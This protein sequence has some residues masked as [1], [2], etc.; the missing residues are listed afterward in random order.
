MS[1]ETH[2]NESTM[3]VTFASENSSDPKLGKLN[4]KTFTLIPKT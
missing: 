2:Y 3:T 4:P 1:K